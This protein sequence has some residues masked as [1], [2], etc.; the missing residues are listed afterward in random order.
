MGDTRGTMADAGPSSDDAQ[1]LTFDTAWT[2]WEH[3]QG[4]DYAQSAKILG[5]CDNVAM[6][7]KYFNNIP[8]PLAFFT[9]RNERRK[10]VGNRKVDALS[11][12]RE[13]VKPEWEDPTRCGMSWF[14]LWLARCSNKAK[15]WLAHGSWISQPKEN[16]NTK[17]RSGFRMA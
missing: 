7:W 15:S 17:S 11:M 6:F 16:K 13:G 10:L 2:W 1:N 9:S 8:R 3:T 5:T 12:F 14:L 4:G